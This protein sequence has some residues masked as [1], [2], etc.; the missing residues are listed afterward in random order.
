MQCVHVCR[1]TPDD[2]RELL[3]ACTAALSDAFVAEHFAYVIAEVCSF[4]KDN[5]MLCCSAGGIELVVAALVAHGTTRPDLAQ[6]GC[7]ALA[8]FAEENQ[9][10]ADAIVLSAGGLDAIYAVMAFYSDWHE[11]QKGACVAL[12]SL[13]GNVGDH[14]WFV[15]RESRAPALLMEVLANHPEGGFRS[16]REY[17]ETAVSK[18]FP[19]AVFSGDGGVMLEVESDESPDNDDPEMSFDE[20]HQYLASLGPRTE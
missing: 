20:M 10:Q 19:G 1:V 18:L 17:A 15:M 9:A 14:A 5:S 13:A 6:D 3:T 8:W 16:A 4:N 7:R 2:V 11:V 12:S